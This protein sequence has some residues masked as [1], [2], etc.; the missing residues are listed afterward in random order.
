MN[1]QNNMRRCE[2]CQPYGFSGLDILPAENRKG[3]IQAF[4]SFFSRIRLIC[5]TLFLNMG[6]RPYT[7][8]KMM[9]G[10][11]KLMQAYTIREGHSP[12]LI[13]EHRNQDAA[14]ETSASRNRRLK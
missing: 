12:R 10:M 1:I 3:K 5:P 9:L 6:S 7:P 14:Q 4:G 2:K 13:S 11:T 8:K